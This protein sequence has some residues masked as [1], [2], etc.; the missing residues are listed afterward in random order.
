MQKS[1]HVSNET[2]KCSAVRTVHISEE[3]SPWRLNFLTL[4]PNI[5]WSTV[6]KLFRTSSGAY[7]F[8]MTT[9][10]WKMFAPL[11]LIT[12]I[13]TRP[14]SSTSFPFRYSMPF[15]HSMRKCHFMTASLCKLGMVFFFVWRC[16]PTRATAFSLSTIT[17][18]YTTLGKTPL[19][20]RSVRRRDLYLTTHNTHKGQHPCPQRDSNPQSEQT[21][22][23]RPR[24][25]WDRLGII[26][27]TS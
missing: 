25:H 24:G 18:R 7:N 2:R 27:N 6:W 9:N 20:E 16:G 4:A 17:L 12:E 8:E 3:R 22:G 5:F 11:I 10:F 26:F 23:R 1:I 14:L 15:S 21:S 19:D 13:R